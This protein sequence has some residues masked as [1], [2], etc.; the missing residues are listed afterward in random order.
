MVL[1]ENSHHFLGLSGFG[2]SSEAPKIEKND[3]HFSPVCFERILSPSGHDQ[4]GELGR[5]KALEP[6]E[7]VEL[8]YLLLNALLQG[9]VPVC[10]LLVQA[11]ELLVPPEVGG[12]RP[13]SPRFATMIRRETPGC[14]AGAAYP[15]P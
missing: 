9:L 13:Q 7:S 3:G 12:E 15:S 2:K 5:E 1:A 8:C 10:E 6:A 4:L 11:P 14:A